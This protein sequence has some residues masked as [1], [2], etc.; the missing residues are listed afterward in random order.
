MTMQDLI[1]AVKAHALAHYESDGWDYVIE[2][3]EDSDLAAL[4][5]DAT[6]VKQAIA[7]VGAAFKPLDDYRADIIGAGGDYDAPERDDY[8]PEGRTYEAGELPEWA[9]P[10]SEGELLQEHLDYELNAQYDYN[11]EAF[12]GM[13][14]DAYEHASYEADRAEEEA[15]LAALPF[16]EQPGWLDLPAAEADALAIAAGYES[17][18][19]C[20]SERVNRWGEMHCAPYDPAGMLPRPMTRAE[21]AATKARFPDDYIP[22]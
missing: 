20:D 14:D 22:F 4:I 12:G 18:S 17:A 16:Y 8:Q 19:D 9:R 6:T 2:T 10:R 1:A 13:I 7:R 21:R 5:G 3:Q 15:R 11:R